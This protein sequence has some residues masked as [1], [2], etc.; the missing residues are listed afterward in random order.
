[1]LL[2]ASIATV[3]AAQKDAPNAISPNSQYKVVILASNEESPGYE[4]GIQRIFGEEPLFKKA[5][6]GW[7]YYRAAESPI[8]LKCLWSPDSKILAIYMRGSKRDGDTSVFSV[9]EDKVNEI[10]IPEMS[11]MLQPYLGKA[12]IRGFFVTPELWGTNHEL[13]LSVVGTQLDEQREDFRLIVALQLVQ[14]KDG[15]FF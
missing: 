12:D 13:F 3:F 2:Q 6:G 11:E 7:V 1:M 5:S 10:K 9:V 8:N 4:I 15:R 14:A